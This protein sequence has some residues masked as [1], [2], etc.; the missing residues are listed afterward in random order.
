MP[1]WWNWQTPGTQNVSRLTPFKTRKAL[2]R[3]GFPKR[4]ISDFRD[5]PPFWPP[6]SEKHPQAPFPSSTYAG[7][8]ELADARDSKSRVRKDVRVR[9]PPPAPSESPESLDFTGFSGLSPFCPEDG[10]CVS[11]TVKN[12][13]KSRFSGNPNPEKPCAARV[14][15]PVEANQEANFIPGR[16]NNRGFC[17]PRPLWSCSQDGCKYCWWFRCHCGPATPGCP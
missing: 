1:V 4:K 2:C 7:V 16:G 15:G 11:E 8:V 12:G 17:W 6:N 3:K 14:S 13:Q 5:W 10:A 9:P